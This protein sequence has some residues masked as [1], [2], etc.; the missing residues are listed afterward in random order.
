MMVLFMLFGIFYG[1]PMIICYDLCK[2]RNRTPAKGIVVGFLG[3]W[4]GVL[5]LWLGLKRRDRKDPRILY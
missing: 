1:L 5:F 4:L 2:E 3:G